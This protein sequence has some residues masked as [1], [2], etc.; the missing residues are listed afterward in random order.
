MENATTAKRPKNWL[1]IKVK[2][3]HGWIG[4]ALSL[5]II[6]VCASGIYLN[7]KDFFKPGE[8]PEKKPDGKMMAA[9]AGGKAGGYREDDER[10]SGALTTRTALVDLPVSFARALDMAEERFGGVAVEKIELRDERGELVYKVK[11]G[12]EREL[13]V[14]ALSGEQA[15]KDGYRHDEASAAG[16]GGRGY[17]WAKIVK[18]LHTGK[19]G[20]EAGKLLI[21]ATSIAVMG[22]TLSGLYLWA[23]PRARKRK[24]AREAAAKMAAAK[25]G[26]G[27]VG[28]VPCVG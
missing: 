6:V 13:I 11:V 26:V 23:V 2:E 10:A 20:G 27:A 25:E 19:I 15:L 16:G 7:H 24:A 5:L 22:L 14:N 17:D 1:L 8:G 3:W 21:D 18:D 4:V 12:E 9:G 28:G